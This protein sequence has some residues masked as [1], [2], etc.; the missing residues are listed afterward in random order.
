M[1]AGLIV[2]ALIINGSLSFLLSLPDTSVENTVQ[3]P[4]A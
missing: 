2:K 4:A 1:A 3:N